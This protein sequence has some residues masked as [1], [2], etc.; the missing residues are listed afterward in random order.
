MKM[1]NKILTLIVSLLCSSTMISQTNDGYYEILLGLEQTQPNIDEYGNLL[2]YGEELQKDVLYIKEKELNYIIDRCEVG[3]GLLRGAFNI[4][5]RM[6]L[7]GRPVNTVWN[8]HGHRFYIAISDL[9]TDDVYHYII[10][11]T[12][13][14]NK[15]K[16]RYY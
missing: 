15:I 9:D 11:K 3:N 14:T 1:N 5:D 8:L 12:E 4:D 16:K 10:P 7:N 2:P 6:L 13:V